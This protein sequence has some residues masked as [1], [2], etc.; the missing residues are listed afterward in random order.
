M[1]EAA[2]RDGVDNT[3]DPTPRS[4]GGSS[5]CNPVAEV[6][7]RKKRDFTT[8]SYGTRYPLWDETF[9]MQVTSG[10]CATELWRYQRVLNGKTAKLKTEMNHSIIT[11]FKL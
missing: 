11:D 6:R 1:R 2:S 3:P 8:T 9:D 5:D 4:I 10:P 7:C